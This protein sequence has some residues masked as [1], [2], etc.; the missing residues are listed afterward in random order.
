MVF[1][2]QDTSLVSLRGATPM[3]AAKSVRVPNRLPSQCPC[4]PCKTSLAGFKLKLLYS[5]ILNEKL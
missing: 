4:T 2:R 5:F 3:H 1:K